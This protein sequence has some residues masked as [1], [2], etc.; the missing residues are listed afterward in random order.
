MSRPAKWNLKFQDA[1]L[2]VP[3]CSEIHF[4]EVCEVLAS[5]CIPQKHGKGHKGLATAHQKE[6][7]KI[8]H[9]ESTLICVNQCP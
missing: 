9:L 3:D 5:P 1:G 8:D 4:H 6:T 7:A 2:T